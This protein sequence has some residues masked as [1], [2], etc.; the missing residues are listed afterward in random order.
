VSFT[1]QPK[2]WKM[3]KIILEFDSIEEKDDAREALDG[4]KW[5]LAMWD[6]DQDLRGIVKHG[7]DGNREATSEEIDVADKVRDKIRRIL[8]DYNLNLE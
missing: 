5:K 8:A 1:G 3:G 6:L 7:Y 4:S 2:L